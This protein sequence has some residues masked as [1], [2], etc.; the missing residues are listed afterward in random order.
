MMKI[1]RV[2]LLACAAVALGSSAARAES[3]GPDCT[4]CQGSIYTLDIF[5]VPGLTDLNLADG[6]FDTWRVKLTIDTTTYNG[7]GTQIDE[8][9]VKISSAIDDVK[10]VQAP[11]GL[12]NWKLVSGGISASGCSGTGSGFECADWIGTGASYV[13]PGAVLTW[14]FDIDVKGGVFAFDGSTELPSIKARY[15]D[16]YGNKVGA[17]VS[18]KVPEPATLTL[19][20][21]GVTI[22]A[23]RRRRSKRATA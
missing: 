5:Q 23:L 9:A 14:I 2:A 17:L 21:M 11:D 3:I 7:G 6:T 19:L 22:A 10:L 20:G 18:E 8:V 15:V 16:D 13:L 4:S 12:S 1:L